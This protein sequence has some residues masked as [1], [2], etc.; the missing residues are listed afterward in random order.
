[1]TTI[2]GINA[3]DQGNKREYSL[4]ASD[5]KMS[6]K[7]KEGEVIKSVHNARKINYNPRSKFIFANSGLPLDPDIRK[8]SSK[9]RY[10]Y[11]KLLNQRDLSEGE[12]SHILKNLG[13]KVKKENSF[14]LAR[15]TGDEITMD[16]FG[17]NSEKKGLYSAMIGSGN[18]Y[19]SS[20]IKD[21]LGLAISNSKGK[22]NLPLKEALKL[23]YEGLMESSK[24]DIFT[25]GH[26]DIGIL[27][28]NNLFLLPRVASL[29]KKE[30]FYGVEQK[31]IERINKYK[32]EFLEG[33]SSLDEILLGV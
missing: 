19:A 4:F 17:G 30:D 25:G 12:I 8:Y 22:R 20:V 27:S 6:A 1:M 7:N 15:D 18:L 11:E 10:F 2:I 29:N 3:Y 5:S 24:E 9:E 16:F 33:R 13:E 14:L 23:C 31:N 32:P 28:K 21:K 26:M